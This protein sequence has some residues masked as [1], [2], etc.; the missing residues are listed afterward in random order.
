MGMVARVGGNLCRTTGDITD[1]WES[2]A[3]IGFSQDKCSPLP[4][5]V[6]GTTPICWS[7]P[8]GVGTQPA[9]VRLTPDEQYTHISLWCLL[10]IAA[11]DRLRSRPARC[12]SPLACLPMMKFWRSTRM[13]WHTS[14]KSEGRDGYQIW[15]KPLADSSLQSGCFTPALVP[16]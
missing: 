10:G 1:T 4:G 6:A 8:G 3:G 5:R 2:M 9:P 14:Q 12:F 7:W 16:L 15:C 11:A 13:S